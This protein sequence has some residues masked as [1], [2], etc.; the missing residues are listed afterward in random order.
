VFAALTAASI[1]GLMSLKVN[2]RLRELLPDDAPSVRALDESRE[3]R[4][5]SDFYTIAVES[6]SARENVAMIEALRARI[7]A[8]W[9]E[10]VWV[11]VD[12]DPSFFREHA[13]L[14]MPVERLEAFRTDLR[15]ALRCELQSVN[16]AFI[17]LGDVCDEEN[18]DWS[19]DAWIGDD[20][21]REL[22]LPEEFFGEWEEDLNPPESEDTGEAAT[23]GGD[24]APEPEGL[25][26][27]LQHYIIS[28]TGTIAVM[29]VQLTGESTDVDFANAMQQR[30]T[31]LIAE[32][33][34][35]SF[36]PDMRAEVVGS[37]QAIQEAKQAVGDSLK[38][39]V[40]SVVMVL[41]IMFLFFRSLRSLLVIV[42]PLAMGLAWAMG[43]TRL[44]YAEL[45][46]YSM[47]VGSVLVGMGI[48]YG[49]H[50]YGRA[51]EGFRAGRSWEDS[52]E[53]ALTH[54]GLSVFASTVTTV[55]ALLTLVTSHFPGFIQFGVIA[56]YGVTLTMLSAY[57]VMPPLVFA[58]E[59]IWPLKRP[60]S[61]A[62]AER[63]PGGSNRFWLA[64]M[65]VMAAMVAYGAMLAP[66]AEFEY[67]FRNLRGPSSSTRIRYGQAV[68]GGR[69]TSPSLILGNSL[70]QMREI[71]ALL[72]ER[73]NSEAPMM[74]GFLTLETY[75][76]ANQEARMAIIQDIDRIVNRR[77]MRR[78]EGEA[79]DFVEGVQE[80]V[81]VEPFRVDEVPIWA[82]R[83]LRESD[84]T[85][86]HLGL[87]FR[88]IQEWDA[89][90]VAVY[91]ASY[92][93]LTVDSGTVAIADSTFINSDIIRIVQADGKQMAVLVT[94]ILAVVLLI[95][96]RSI[97][98]TLICL[99]VM[100]AALIL[101]AGVMVLTNTRVG[102]YNM[103]V[104]P[105]VLGVSIDGAIH[106]F[107]RYREAESGRDIGYVMK[108]TGAA[109]AASL[110]T[111]AGGFAGLLF[112][113][114]MGI[115]S[116]GELA[117]IGMLSALVA[118]FL[119]MPGLL[120]L[121][122]GKRA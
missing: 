52:I 110:A 32:L 26:V 17:E 22:G 116:I 96:L 73:F 20:L 31:A 97:T 12:E 16:P 34:P 4:G 90:E 24:A 84:G 41:A 36:H 78:L 82:I 46:L 104:M 108:T 19:V 69:T 30:G 105:A 64:P 1:V 113:D 100:G 56:S 112:Q 89:Q 9:P 35:A 3:R 65:A 114:H 23:A 28:P 14:Y 106:L 121:F 79:R 83:T 54:T 120:V 42:V 5:S 33:D 18:T 40:F 115:R 86:G 57:L 111:T 99:F 61:Q 10:A 50:L 87:I 2:T 60:S 122:G 13:M 77:A 81:Q 117:V 85:V 92:G 39:F 63:S 98:G 51:M 119:F 47:F 8:D 109:V 37:Y 38:A 62:P 72:R 76:P 107:N 7:E 48:D 6:P 21:Y 80:L 59:R 70:E 43:I 75:V 71:H 94:I 68:G 58:F 95:S 25:P 66:D 67:D 74:K 49:I 93:T 11:Q 29:Y 27:D 101:A 45:N 88:Q 15:V 102:M 91:Q 44:I 55:G 118:I 103:I 53:E